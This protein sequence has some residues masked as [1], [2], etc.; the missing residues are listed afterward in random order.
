MLEPELVMV[1]VLV[2]VQGPELVQALELE[3]VLGQVPEREQVLV[4]HRRQR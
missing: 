2:Q 3:L 4:Q 1:L